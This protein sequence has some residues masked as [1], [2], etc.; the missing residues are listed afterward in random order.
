MQKIANI[1]Q[2]YKDG[3]PIVTQ[4]EYNLY[5]H[6][7]IENLDEIPKLSGLGYRKR[8]AYARALAHDGQVI[9]IDDPLIGVDEDGVRIILEL[10]TQL[11]SSK[12]L[13]IIIS[14]DERVFKGC[15]RFL[16]LDDGGKVKIKNVKN[17]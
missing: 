10:L 1:N 9:I 6:N 16:N 15:G 8:L 11:V 13:I 5:K 12:K 3:V 17:F 7:F 2:D 14:N 4:D